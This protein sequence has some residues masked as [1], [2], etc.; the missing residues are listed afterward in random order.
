MRPE[1]IARAIV[2]LTKGVP[3]VVAMTDLCGGL[4]Y[5]IALEFALHLP[6][7]EGELLA[8]TWD[9]DGPRR[10]AWLFAVWCT[11]ELTDNALPG[12]IAEEP[13]FGGDGE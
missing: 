12:G 6:G 9:T 3:A 11:H 10:A 5:P 4:L 13:Y 1:A 7:E 8:E 2:E